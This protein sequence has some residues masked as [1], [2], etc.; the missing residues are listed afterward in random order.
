VRGFYSSSGPAGASVLE[1]QDQLDRTETNRGAALRR[2]FTSSTA[3][4]IDT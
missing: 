2:M 1:E 4:I 3:F